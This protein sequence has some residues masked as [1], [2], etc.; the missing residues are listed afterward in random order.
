MKETHFRSGKAN[1]ADANYIAYK[2]LI[3][4]PAIARNLAQ[5]FPILI[6]DEAQIRLPF[7]WQSLIY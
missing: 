4:Y 1:Q 7:K 5:R 2:I 6:I 3:K